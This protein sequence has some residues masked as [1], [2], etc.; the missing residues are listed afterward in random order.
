MN[1]FENILQRSAPLARAF[2]RVRL[3]VATFCDGAA[4]RDLAPSAAAGALLFAIAGAGLG[5]KGGFSAFK[6]DAAAA[7]TVSVGWGYL[8]LG[9]ALG[10]A[11][12]GGFVG[13]ASAYASRRWL[14]AR[15][16]GFALLA[17]GALGGVLAGS[18]WGTAVARE[19]VVELRARQATA[20]L[21]DKARGPRASVVSGPVRLEGTVTRQMNVPLLVFMV[22]GGS[23]VGLFTARGL[24]E[25][26]RFVRREEKQPILDD[27]GRARFQQAA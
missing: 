25:P 22:V 12:T 9:L 2:D 27:L 14:D 4:L 7:A 1:F 19:R 6:V 10:G 26:L 21:P 20:P 3:A 15:R 5:A 18:T 16:A 8:W 24:R 11:A 23:V 17:V 13:A